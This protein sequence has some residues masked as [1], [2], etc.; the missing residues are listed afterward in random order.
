MRNSVKLINV[1]TREQA[2]INYKEFQKDVKKNNFECTIV[3]LFTIAVGLTIIAALDRYVTD[4]VSFGLF[5]AITCLIG[6]IVVHAA[7]EGY[8]SDC[9]LVSPAEC[10][11]YDILDSF[12]ILKTEIEYNRGLNNYSLCLTTEN[13][14]REVG[15]K[16]ILGFNKITRT[17]IQ[18]MCVDL[19]EKTIYVP[20]EG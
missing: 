10:Q 4:E 19:E 20:Y 2:N 18:E 15:Y 5:A 17:D 11:Y 14:K 12:R 9:I 1:P 13:E 6:G 3:L 8:E 7:I 16:W